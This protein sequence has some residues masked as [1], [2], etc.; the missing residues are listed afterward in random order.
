MVRD[1]DRHGSAEPPVQERPV[2][3]RW[4]TA[5]PKKRLFGRIGNKALARVCHNVGGGLHA[6]VDIRR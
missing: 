5:R 4:Q 2:Q 1:R 3:E 6:G